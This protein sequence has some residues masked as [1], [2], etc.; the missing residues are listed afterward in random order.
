[1][2]NEIEIITIPALSDNYIFLI[3]NRLKNLTSV[4]DPAE[5][6]PVNLILEQKGWK[7]DQI[8][9]THHHHDHTQGNQSLKNTWNAKI[10]GPKDEEDK[11][12][13]LDIQVR[14]LDKIKIAGLDATVIHTPGHTLGHVMYHF[15]NEYILFAGDTIF[16]LGCGRVFE[17]TM[18]NMW[19]SL[20]KIRDMPPN[21]MIYC[22]HE[23]TIN[24]LKFALHVD[25]NNKDLLKFGEHIHLT[26][27]K[28]KPSIPTLLSTEL[29]C[30]PFLRVDKDTI[31]K[32][33][34]SDHKNPYQVFSL[35]RAK[36][37]NF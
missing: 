33:V 35:L 10:V 3:H 9:N 8:I 7:L 31:S 14:N 1:M 16:S 21:T 36:K 4:I 11:I 34:N 17:G 2:N 28:Q 27:S 25:P 29:A 30:N 32:S 22:G 12:L 13:D 24:N 5:V 18:E 19:E 6:K 26:R 37:D 23:Y 15:P 20:V